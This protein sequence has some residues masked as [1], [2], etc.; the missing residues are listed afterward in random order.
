MHSRRQ[1]FSLKPADEAFTVML[2]L[3]VMSIDGR[4][5]AK[6]LC[7]GNTDLVLVIGFASW[8]ARVPRSTHGGSCG[9]TCC[10]LGGRRAEAHLETLRSQ[11]LFM[12]L[13]QSDA[14]LRLRAC[15]SRDAHMRSSILA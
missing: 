10:M 3:N 8:M 7:L 13:Y 15:T 9:C 11:A 5:L 4:Q 2:F 12:G 6:S 14:L 1:S